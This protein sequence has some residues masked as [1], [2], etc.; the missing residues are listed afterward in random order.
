MRVADSASQGSVPNILLITTDQQRWDT[1]GDA[2]PAWMM[3]PHFDHLC[4]T[5]IVFS[6]AYAD[7]PVCVPARVSIMTGKTVLAHGMTGNGSSSRA[8]DRATSLPS[9]LRA[10]GYQTCAIG[11]MHF[12]PQRARHG[13][14][15]MV[16]PDD[17]YREQQRSG[18]PLQPMRHG[19]GQNELY[20]A[21]ATVPETQTLTSWTTE[22][23]VDY[24]RF[25]RDPDL[26]FFLWC[27]YS[28]PHPPLD[29]PEP[30]YSLYRGAAIA[31][32][33]VGDWAYG[34]ACPPIVA[35]TRAGMNSDR[36]SPETLRA[37]RAAYAGLI[38]QIDYNL[39]RLFAALQEQG[40]WRNTLVLYTSDHGELLGDHGLGGKCYGF[41][42]SAHVP[43]V[44]HLPPAWTERFHGTVRTEPVTHADILPTLVNLA[45]GRTP[46]ACDGR[47]LLAPVRG[48]AAGR[49]RLVVAGGSNV[50][51]LSLVEG[52]WKYMWFEAGGRELLFNLAEDPLET[53]NLAGEAV[54]A[55]RCRALR[56]ALV[57]TLLAA[58]DT[59]YLQE[60]GLRA[61]PV[62]PASERDLRAG[63]G[64]GWITEQ[65]D[66]DVR[67]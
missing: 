60:G 48:R 11:K 38:T 64:Y 39:G 52:D 50:R 58:G 23:C 3:T 16:L 10:S 33:A 24:L 36:L 43:F 54:Q 17:Y 15:E 25:R 30:Y 35:E 49:D 65:A 29:P 61:Q 27:S 42:G 8:I 7:C 22:R 53:R 51:G 37:A 28:K 63:N 59:R 47:D 1:A 45:G 40:L 26:P 19:L 62:N 20:P 44:L 9:C 56:A 21:M 57:E 4:R 14:D 31:P 5:G 12:T 6:R 34:P 18:S 13:F 41:E 66:A 67:H 46:A 32:P 55:A 2:K